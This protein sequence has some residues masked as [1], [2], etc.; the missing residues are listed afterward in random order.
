MSS[1]CYKNGGNFVED[2]L[3]D[4]F[5]QSIDEE[6]EISNTKLAWICPAWKGKS[7]LDA[8]NYRPI[9]LTNII[10]K[11]LEGIFRKE[12]IDHMVKAKIIDD[13]QHGSTSGRSTV[14]QLLDQQEQILSMIEKGENAELIFLDFSKAYDK[15]D[16]RICLL[17][18]G[19]IGIKAKNLKWIEN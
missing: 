12:I 9:A 10:S 6:N 16:H 13:D 7:K 8:V 3:I 1:K 4:I 19:E 2:A 15:I 5:N 18:L 11:I 17:K 14:S